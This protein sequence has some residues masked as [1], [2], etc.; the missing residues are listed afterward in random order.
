[1]KNDEINKITN[2]IFVEFDAPHDDF[3]ELDYDKM[4]S[5][6]FKG[7]YGI[8]VDDRNSFCEFTFFPHHKEIINHMESVPLRTNLI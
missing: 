6:H 7:V 5:T 8:S 3:R 1:M 4:N 2:N